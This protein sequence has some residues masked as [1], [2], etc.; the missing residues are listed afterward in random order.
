MKRE[1]GRFTVDSSGKIA[2]LPHVS[3]VMLFLS[4]SL[5]L[6]A[7]TLLPSWFRRRTTTVVAVVVLQRVTGG[8][9]G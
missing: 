2:P 6:L 7:A 4:L 3:F 8:F 9:V 5:S 1:L